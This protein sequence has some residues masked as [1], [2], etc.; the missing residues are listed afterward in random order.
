M[1]KTR[2]NARN[3]KEEERE[4]AQFS[5]DFSPVIN[6]LRSFLPPLIRILPLRIRCPG[7]PFFLRQSDRGRAHA[8]KP[9]P[10]PPGGGW[11]SFLSLSLSLS[12]SPCQRSKRR[13]R[14]GRLRGSLTDWSGERG[15]RGLSFLSSFLPPRLCVNAAHDRRLPHEKNRQ[16]LLSE[17]RETQCRRR[18]RFDKPPAFKLLA[19]VWRIPRYIYSA[20]ASLLCLSRHC[21]F[22]PPPSLSPPSVQKKRTRGGGMNTDSHTR[23]EARTTLSTG[24]KYYRTRT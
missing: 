11:A 21:I 13:R 16:T 3:R 10:L 6:Y 20:A 24:V 9:S 2:K 4:K 1:K 8:A 17:S 23:L 18:R 5:A 15:E 19:T 14:N 22:P 7:F 12:L